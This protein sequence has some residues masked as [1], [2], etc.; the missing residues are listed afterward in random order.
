[1]F[2]QG[3]DEKVCELVAQ[4]LADRRDWADRE[5]KYLDE[6]EALKAER[7]A[8]SAQVADAFGD[9]YY[10]GFLDGAKHHEST[11]CNT[12]PD[13]LG[14]DAMRCSEIAENEKS[15]RLGIVSRQELA[16]QVEVFKSALDVVRQ[17]SKPSGFGVQSPQGARAERLAWMRLNEAVNATPAQCLR[18]IQAE[19]GRAGFL[20]AAQIY[21]DWPIDKRDYVTVADKYA[22]RIR[23]GGA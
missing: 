23:Q 13:Y 4:S 19:A 12:N 1:M 15:K 7:D 18:E 14:D 16:A 10:D 9:G 20:E 2:T 8:L 3:H 22:D 17:T 6:L 11:D 21:A 5:G